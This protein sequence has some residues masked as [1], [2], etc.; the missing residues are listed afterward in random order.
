MITGTRVKILQ[1]RL[2]KINDEVLVADQPIVRVS[3]TDIASLKHQALANAR[4]RIRICTHPDTSDRLHEMLIVHTRGT[5]VRPH[6]HL[7]KSESV[8]IIEGEVDIVFLDEAGDVR[9]VVRL[10]DF[11]SGRDFYCRANWPLY[12]TLLIATDF[13]VFHEITNG[14]FQREDT[15]FAPWAPEE[16]NT[17]A[18]SE[19]QARVAREAARHARV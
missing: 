14:P 7:N 12:H 6:K 15:V 10:G 9:D 2:N 18:C 11:R 13:L 5:Y 16:S 8:H 3:G 4:R 19:F 1:M 17:L